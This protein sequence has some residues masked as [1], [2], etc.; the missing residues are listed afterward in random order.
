MGSVQ[1][2]LLMALLDSVNTV[3]LGAYG[4]VTLPVTL[5]LWS[6]A[7]VFRT[8]IMKILFYCVLLVC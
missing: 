1:L 5:L 8:E 4:K 6:P 2:L 3:S 7:L